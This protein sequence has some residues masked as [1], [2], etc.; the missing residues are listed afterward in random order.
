[1]PDLKALRERLE[2]MADR[3][4]RHQRGTLAEMDASH[5]TALIAEE[6]DL[7]AA[8]RCVQALDDARE[9]L[10]AY[11]QENDG[12]QWPWWAVV[13]N[14]GMGDRGILAGPFFSRERAEQH[15]KAREHEYGRKSLVWCFSGHHSQHYR[16]LI[17]AI[18]SAVKHG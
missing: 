18:E 1:M 6:A 16:G 13:R 15:R 11:G 5:M 9:T 7:R 14:N 8:A 12:T 2:K 3:A 10:F 17:E 4:N